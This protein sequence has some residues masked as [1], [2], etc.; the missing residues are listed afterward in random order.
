[1]AMGRFFSE[2]ARADFYR[3]YDAAAA[4]WPVPAEELDVPTR[5]GSTRVRRWGTS[6]SPLVLLHPNL[7]TSLVWAPWAG[8]LALHHRVLAVDTIGA[9]GRSV[10][11]RP[12]T[13]PTD[14]AHWLRDVLEA[15]EPGQRAHVAGFSEGGYVA[16]CGALPPAAPLASVVAIDPGGIAALRPGFLLGMAAAGLRALVSRRALRDYA[17]RFAPELPE[18]EWDLMLSGARHFRAGLPFPR[19]FDDDTLRG[20]TLPTLLYLGAETQLYDAGLAAARARALLPDVE[21]VLVEGAGHGVPFTHP[22]RTQAAVLDFI[23]R[24]EP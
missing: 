16:L 10:Q 19:R 1:M 3:R 23:A 9:L 14:L 12:L 17:R 20:L 18:Q 11:T 24:H 13:G 15:V 5:Y 6:G 8:T 22:E 2:R 4:R 7:G 21:V